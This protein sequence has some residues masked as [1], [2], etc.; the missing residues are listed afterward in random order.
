ME[1]I[2][3]Y[4][5]LG[6]GLLVLIGTVMHWMDRSI[7]WFAWRRH[8]REIEATKDENDQ[9]LALMVNGMMREQFLYGIG[10]GGFGAATII[11]IFSNPSVQGMLAAMIFALALVMLAKERRRRVDGDREQLNKHI[12]SYYVPSS[13]AL[14]RV[15][16]E[17]VQKGVLGPSLGESEEEWTKRMH[18]TK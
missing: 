6:I 16:R 2:I 14:G 8:E 5:I 10:I 9:E 3:Y 11:I 12:A 15:I 7:D 18:I 17:A 4:A 1:A 13:I